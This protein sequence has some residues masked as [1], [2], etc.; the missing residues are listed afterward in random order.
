MFVCEFD[1]TISYSLEI[2]G[3]CAESLR[4][5]KGVRQRDLLSPYLFVLLMDYLS[6]K[7]KKMSSLKEF[8]FH[9]RC[10]RSGIINLC[11]TDDLDD[12]FKS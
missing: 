4:A 8:N 2:N 1:Q 5:V 6:S 3:T 7:L 11:F 12:L 9:P 10:K